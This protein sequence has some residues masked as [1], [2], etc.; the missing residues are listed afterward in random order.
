[1]NLEISH[2]LL[3]SA[4]VEP[5]RKRYNVLDIINLLHFDHDPILLYNRLASLYKEYYEP[6]DR[7][8]IL[9]FDADYYIEANNHLPG[10][11][12]SNLQLILNELNIPN[13]F[14]LLFT[15]YNNIGA[16]L[17]TAQKLYSRDSISLPYVICYLSVERTQRTLNVSDLNLNTH[18]LTK[19]YACLN[20]SS[21]SHRT[22]FIQL[23]K[24][25]NL[26]DQGLVSFINLKKSFNQT[27][28]ND[29]EFSILQD[30]SFLTT[31]PFVRVNDRWDCQKIDNIIDTTIPDPIILDILTTD[32]PISPFQNLDFQKCFVYVATETVFNYPHSYISE[33]SFKGITSK[34]PFIILGA[35]RCLT[36]LKDL[37]YKTFG[38][39]WD[40]S[41]DSIADPADRMLAVYNLVNDICQK[42][43]E[44]LKD[45]LLGMQDILDYNFNHYTNSFDQQLIKL[46]QDLD[47]IEDF[48][49]KQNQKMLQL[50]NV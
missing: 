36:V 28:S 33:K 18:A 37:G 1:M 3:P 25:N 9:H 39:Y 15:V 2:V 11:T 7:I 38:D 46:N 23:L 47:R 34:R 22:K 31:C 10:F 6:N 17:I 16:E 42:P 19:K 35:P 27:L 40:E 4:V 26:L 50:N 48:F 8:I 20:G 43:I 49:D 44:E 5:L 21:K 41:Y 32:L 45:M 29:Q 30:V 13:Q 24:T 14:V 12:I